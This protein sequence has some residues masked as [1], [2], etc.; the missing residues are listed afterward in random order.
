LSE[1]VCP[2]LLPVWKMPQLTLPAKVFRRRTL[3]AAFSTHTP[4]FL[5]R[6]TVLASIV[7][8]L[9]PDSSIPTLALSSTRLEPIVLPLDSIHSPVLLPCTTLKL[10]ALALEPTDNAIPICPLSREALARIV[11][12][13][14]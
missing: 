8:D 10:T 7:F 3:L 11:P 6:R 12:F 5:L 13:T 9:A 4:T 2:L 14:H 1:I